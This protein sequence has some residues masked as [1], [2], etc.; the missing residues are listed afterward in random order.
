MPCFSP[1]KTKNTV[2]F[3]TS[4]FNHTN[5][6]NDLRGNTESEGQQRIDLAYQPIIDLRTGKQHRR[7]HCSRWKHPELGLIPTEILLRC[8][9]TKMIIPIRTGSL[10]RL[11]S[12]HPMEIGRTSPFAVGSTFLRLY[13][14]RGNQLP[15]KNSVILRRKNLNHPPSISKTKVRHTDIDK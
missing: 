10:K 2:T 12:D 3:Y 8:R 4:S 1:K 14:K 5:K 13:R 6:R 11:R 9:E 15:E 7:K